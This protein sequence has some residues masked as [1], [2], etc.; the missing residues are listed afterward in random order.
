MRAD[1]TILVHYTATVPAAGKPVT[2][3]LI[4]PRHVVAL[5]GTDAPICFVREELVIADPARADRH[6]LSWNWNTFPPVS[7]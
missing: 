4:N 3:G 6:Q 2:E 5:A 1:G 7:F